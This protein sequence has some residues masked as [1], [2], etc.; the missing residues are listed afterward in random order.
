MYKYEYG[1]I[2]VWC[3]VGILAGIYFF[4]RGFYILW[5]KRLIQDT[6]TS[7]IRSL[8]VGFLEITG[9]TIADY[10][11]VTPYSAAPCV[12]YHAIM[13]RLKSTSR[14]NRYWVK[15]SDYKSDVPFYLQDDTGCVVID[16]AGAETKL[17]LRYCKRE[18]NIRY[19]E[20]YIKESEFIYV[21]GTAKKPESPYDREQKE[22][23][24]RIGEIVND[25]EK[26]VKL[27]KNKDN[28][29]DKQEWEAEKR[30]IRKEIE[31]EMKKEREEKDETD[32]IVSSHL[33][34][35]I[36]GKGEGVK[37][38]IISTL[39][40]KMLVQTMHIKAVSSIFGGAILT[41]ICLSIILRIL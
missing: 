21:L 24:R 20:Y 12:F 16:P 33:K 6:P 34:N 35:I 15:E 11:L 1:R 14:N 26:K 29:I 40:E 25:P 37:D 3:I 18:G 10:L 2:F 30:Q 39:G 5:R 38:F 22:M 7:K 31:Q 9:Q 28:W 27:D 17:P 4:F 19:K 13:E 32:S 36:I 23:E 41:L 8:A